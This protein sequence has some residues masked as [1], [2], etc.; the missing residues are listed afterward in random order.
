[1]QNPG[2]ELVC[3]RRAKVQCSSEAVAGGHPLTAPGSGRALKG[4][5]REVPVLLGSGTHCEAAH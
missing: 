5:D 1:M 2:K 4:I 3:I